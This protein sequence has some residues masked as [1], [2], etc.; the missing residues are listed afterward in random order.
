V[1]TTK[2][3][4]KAILKQ[5]DMAPIDTDD[6]AAYNVVMNVVEPL[7]ATLVG[8]GKGGFD[9]REKKVDDFRNLI[10]MRFGDLE[11]QLFHVI[12]VFQGGKFDLSAD[13]VIADDATLIILEESGKDEEIVKALKKLR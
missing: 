10:G 5:L 9:I 3:D 2:L 8:I 7:I 11:G 12:A 4:T 13:A 6:A 1:R